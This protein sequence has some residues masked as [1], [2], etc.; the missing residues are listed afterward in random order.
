MRWVHDLDAFNRLS[1]Q[2]Q[3]AVFGRTKRESDEIAERTR[4][5]T[6][7]ISRV[8]FEVEGR[9]LELYRR[10]VPFG[11]LAEAGLY[12]VAFSADPRR[13]QLLLARMFGTSVDGVRDRLT[14]FSRPTSGAVYFVPSLNALRALADPR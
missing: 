12:F 11:L 5:P 14:D 3:E 1:V 7:H 8:Q 13:F 10:S 4:P 6:A 2:E 9:E